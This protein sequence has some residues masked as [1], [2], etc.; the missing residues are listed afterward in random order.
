MSSAALIALDQ[1]LVILVAALWGCAGGYA[2]ASRK[3]PRLA[4]AAAAL[5]TG[6]LLGTAGRVATV[7]LLAGHGWWFAG[8]KVLLALPLLLPPAIAAAVVSLPRLPRVARGT[9]ILPPAVAVLPLAACYAAVAGVLITFSVGYPIRGYLAAV[10]VAAVLA[11]TAATW[12]MLTRTGPPGRLWQVAG[13]V[14]ALLALAWT[15]ASLWNARPPYE[16]RLAGGGGVDVTALRGGD[17]GGEVRR[18]T[19]TARPA[20]VTLRS[21][22]KVEA[23]TFN[24]G[25]PGPQIRVRQGETVEVT[26]ASELVDRGVTLHWHG[27]HV[28][29]GEDGVPGVT[30]DAV[31]RGGRFV[32]R[33]TADQPGSYWYHTHETPNLGLQKGLFGAFV[34]D[35]AAPSGFDEAV[36]LHS[37]DGTPTTSVGSGGPDDGMVSR[38]VA[39]G[40]AVR[41]RVVNTDNGPH[42]VGVA[43]VPYRIGAV[44]GMPV[45]GRELTGERAQLAAGGRY[46]LTFT[47]PA[48]PVALSTE[49]PGTGL[50]LTP[51]S[52]AAPPP[53]SGPL[54]DITRYGTRGPA[55]PTRFDRDYTWVLDRLLVPRS[56]LP[57][58]S[59]TVN[60][61]V[62]PRI[63]APVVAEGEWVRFTVVNRSGDLHPM[64][65][66]GHHVLVLSR[67]GVPAAPLWMDSFD[68]AP[69]EVWEVALKADNPGV[70][71]SHCHELKHAAEGMTLHFTY[72]GVRSPF[73]VGE[74][75]ANH[76]D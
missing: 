34:V 54:I 12:R 20:T 45:E 73:A 21:G 9:A 41:L 70:W 49:N 53:P 31:R 22:R 38:T 68:V 62:W 64:H 23:L 11:G 30:Q 67:D 76:P 44:D 18:F 75:M 15:G 47:M 72:E 27:Y 26:L 74:R 58:P 3:V 46:D 66:H 13:S 16:L 14:V 59:Y 52:G 24:G 17:G 61:E 32:Y 57:L 40:T 63:P 37:F 39:P 43:G 1:I 42:T 10:L 55:V 25:S 71:L 2:L 65:P 60:G 36:L 6:A 5:L 48:R 35:A 19:L 4:R 29:N 7:A 28:P 51:G 8:E 69:G 50:L 56:G 33:F